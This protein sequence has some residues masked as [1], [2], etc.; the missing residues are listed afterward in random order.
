MDTKRFFSGLTAMALSIGFVLTVLAGCDSPTNGTNGGTGAGGVNA[1]NIVSTEAGIRAAF[2]DG[3]DI[4]HL[5]GAVD[6]SDSLTVPALKTLVVTSTGDIASRSVGSGTGS[7]TVK[8]GG[9]L[10]IAGDFKVETVL[11]VEKT[12]AGSGGTFVALVGSEVEFGANATLAVTSGSGFDVSAITPVYNGNTAAQATVGTAE[13][14]STVKT[15]ATA[16]SISGLYTGSVTTVYYSGEDDITYTP[17]ASGQTLVVTGEVDQ[18]TT[19]LTVAGVL[20]INGTGSLAASSSALLTIN[21]KLTIKEEGVYDTTGSDATPVIGANAVIVND[22][23]FKIGAS[24]DGAATVTTGAKFSGAGYFETWAADSIDKILTGSVSDGGFNTLFYGYTTEVPAA[25]FTSL[26]TGKVLVTTAAWTMTGSRDLSTGKGTLVIGNDVLTVGAN[27]LTGNATT[28][29]IIVYEG[30][31]IAL[32][33]TA[34]LLAGKIDVEYGGTIDVS[35][36]ITGAIPVSVNFKAGSV[37]DVGA[38]ADAA[39]IAAPLTYAKV[40]VTSD[41][42]TLQLPEASTIGELAIGGSITISGGATSI[43]I[44]KL[45]NSTADTLTLPVLGAD[46]ISIGTIVTHG[47]NAITLAGATGA[48]IGSLSGGTG[49]VV[50]PVSFTVKGAGNATNGTVVFPAVAATI[51][52]LS[53]AEGLTTVK[54]AAAAYSLAAGETGLD[55]GSAAKL[56]AGSSGITFATN[57][58]YALTSD[59]LARL[60]GGIT[61]TASNA[62]VASLTVPADVTLTIVTGGFGASAAITVDGTLVISDDN[63]LPNIAETA[64]VTGTGKLD[65]SAETS[66][67]SA[68]N[69]AKLLGVDELKVLVDA[70]GIPAAGLTVPTGKILNLLGASSEVALADGSTLTVNGTL[71]LIGGETMALLG[72]SG[73]TDENATLTGSGTINIKDT[74]AVEVTGAEGAVGLTFGAAELTIDGTLTVNVEGAAGIVVTG[75]A[76]E[77]VSGTTA[78]IGGAGAILIIGNTATVYIPLSNGQYIKAIGGAGGGA[79]Q[80][81][82]KAGGGGGGGAVIVGNGR[83]R[84]TGTSTARADYTLTAATAHSATYTGGTGGSIVLGNGG[85]HAGVTPGGQGMGVGADSTTDGDGGVG[86]A[87]SATVPGAGGT[88]GHNSGSTNSLGGVGGNNATYGGGGGGGGGTSGDNG[89]GGGGGGAAIVNAPAA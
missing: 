76:G 14:A 63:A 25:A 80:S 64:P 41:S 75:G 21:G 20:V 13:A 9:E 33:E 23:T 73:G 85:V 16:G 38:D 86:A 62:A 42:A 6:I 4:V 29:N 82:G 44:T 72:V 5:V 15:T 18:D 28:A 66:G 45:T 74:A 88:G 48:T 79:G 52:G 71:N 55:I 60:K 77:T 53:T 36:A 2:A 12:P 50:L 43:A 70:T 67:Y 49:G 40:D 10:I 65:V 11:T 37:L 89:G 1:P 81:G 78:G 61:Y 35:G 69:I 84:T 87:S 54:L 26:T 24:D 17:L 51:V 56:A 57:A 46:K 59:K 34:S 31:T 32:S 7:I 83:I 68:A 27:T 22:G 30:G 8:E 58:P 19:S 47:S 3:Y 39:V